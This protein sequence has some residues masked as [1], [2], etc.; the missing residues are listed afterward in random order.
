MDYY[1]RNRAAKIAAAKRAARRETIKQ[2]LSVIV[3]LPVLWAM[4][5]LLLC[6]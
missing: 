1:T 5:V 3:A 4:M 6:I 2:I